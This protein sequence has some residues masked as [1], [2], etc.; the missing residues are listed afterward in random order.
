MANSLFL[1]LALKILLSCRATGTRWHPKRSLAPLA[2]ASRANQL[3][4][5]DRRSIGA[6][7]V[8]TE[9]SCFYKDLVS[10]L[11]LNK[12]LKRSRCRGMAFDLMTHHLWLIS[13]K[14]LSKPQL[15]KIEQVGLS[16]K[17]DPRRLPAG[18]HCPWDASNRYRSF[19]LQV[20]HFREK[21]W[22]SDYNVVY[23]RLKS[24]IWSLPNSRTLTRP[25]FPR[26][27]EKLP[28]WTAFFLTWS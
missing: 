10:Q 21:F 24:K 16:P 23:S 20:T 12:T 14:V 1:Y 8:C 22:N 26:D 28:F 17:N 15:Q 13:D 25:G 7:C 9:K 2:V 4:P 6:K 3:S 11:D 5:Y 27:Q 19:D 18:L